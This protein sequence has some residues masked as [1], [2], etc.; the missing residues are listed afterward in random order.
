VLVS[1]NLTH[2]HVLGGQSNS[3]IQFNRG[4][5][6]LSTVSRTVS[7]TVP[8]NSRG[9]GGRGGDCEVGTAITTTGEG[10]EEEDGFGIT[11]PLNC[12]SNSNLRENGAHHVVQE[13]TCI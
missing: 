3:G 4:T 13:S 2:E 6:H 9:L 8:H 7:F 11:K 10:D 12:P 5:I 1:L